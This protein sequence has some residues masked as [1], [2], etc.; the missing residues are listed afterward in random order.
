MVGALLLAACQ[1]AT[2]VEELVPDDVVL[3]GTGPE[4][5]TRL[6]AELAAALVREGGMAA[7][8]VEL[9][10]TDDARRALEIGDVDVLPSY[11]GEAWLRVLG[12][13]DPPSDQATSLARVREFDEQRGLLW[14][15]PRVSPSRDLT[16]PPADA[17]FAFVV[18]GAPGPHAD[19]VTLSQ[20]AS[21][22]AQIEAPTLCV[23]PSFAQRED[24]LAAVL[25]AYSVAP[26]SVEVLA[27]APADAVLG[28]A[29][30]GCDAGLTSATDG[31]AWRAGQRPLLDDLGVFPAFVVA[32]VVRDASLRAYPGL[33]A[34]LDPML[35]GLTTAWLGIW[36]ARV[37]GGESAGFV[38]RDAVLELLGA[39]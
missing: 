13:A 31:R 36:N 16:A 30:G 27:V 17:T 35:T 4:P 34:A 26:G 2:L 5:E 10:D 3:V 38:A 1:S 24:G 28:V 32:P 11:T 39:S 9:A 19:V 7:A 37:A 8:V 6:L 29:A 20:L 22:L 23:D 14:L 15:R 33:E 25:D 21:R 12:R 18:Q